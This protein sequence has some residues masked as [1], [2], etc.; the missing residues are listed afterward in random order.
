MFMDTADQPD[1]PLVIEG[2]IKYDAMNRGKNSLKNS[3][4]SLGAF[5]KHHKQN[6]IFD[7]TFND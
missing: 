4:L 3:I 2:M 7:Y 1:T 6:F 5:L